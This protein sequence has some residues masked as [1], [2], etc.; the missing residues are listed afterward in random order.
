[1]PA[2]LLHVLSVA[3]EFDLVQTW[4]KARMHTQ[5]WLACCVSLTLACRSLWRLRSSCWTLALWLWMG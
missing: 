1:V 2:S 4:N 3:R 5:R